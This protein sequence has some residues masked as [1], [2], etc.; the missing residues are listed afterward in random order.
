MVYRACKLHSLQLLWSY[1]TDK[2]IL[3]LLAVDT[4]VTQHATL[5]PV[6]DI[7]IANTASENITITCRLSKGNASID[8]IWDIRDDHIESESKR[9]K[10]ADNGVFIE[11]VN[12]TLSILV[13]TFEGRRNLGYIPIR[14]SSYNKEDI[15]VGI[16]NISQQSNIIPFGMWLSNLCIVHMKDCCVALYTYPIIYILTTFSHTD[17]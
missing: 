16:I 17:G 13:V 8:I 4:G 14:C 5:D 9:Q 1:V 2:L 7:T 3:Q 10:L 15:R 11:D 6:G 12:A